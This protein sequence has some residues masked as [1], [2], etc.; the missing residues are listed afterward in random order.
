MGMLQN[1]A[2]EIFPT[3]CTS[4]ATGVAAFLKKSISNPSLL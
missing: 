4:K 2:D 1:R 3:Q